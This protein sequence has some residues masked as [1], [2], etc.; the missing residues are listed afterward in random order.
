MKSPS[1]WI[2]DIIN[3]TDTL[4]RLLEG[5]N[6]DRFSS[7]ER[8]QL[9]IVKLIENIGEA[10]SHLIDDFK[11][12]YPHVPWRKI[13]AMRNQLAH[14]YWDID[15]KVVWTVATKQAQELRQDLQPILQQIQSQETKSSN[16]KQ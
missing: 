5:Y 6:F 4:D 8:T 14:Q 16:Q 10:C 12:D 2:I 1:V 9:A 15:F 3:A 11:S 13:K 7:D